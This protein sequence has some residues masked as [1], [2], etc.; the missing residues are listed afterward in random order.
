MI[1][2]R[3]S[4]KLLELRQQ[5]NLTQKQLCEDLNISR[6]VYSYFEC[7]R[8]T[9][10][11]DTLLLFAEYYG[12]SLDELV[13]GTPAATEKPDTGTSGCDSA[14]AISRHLQ[15]KHIPVESILQ[16]SKADFDFLT[17]YKKLSPDN[18]AEM[19][20]LMKYKIRKQSD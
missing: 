20:Y 2:N 10:D 18:Q 8:R 14:V 9:P 3:I 19:T 6:S 4:L 1:K 5:R 12:V 13:T 15:S 16:M 11:I 7:E 17:D